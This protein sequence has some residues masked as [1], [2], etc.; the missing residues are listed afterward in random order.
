MRSLLFILMLAF[1]SACS[2]NKANVKLKVSQSF[3][4]SAFSGGAALLMKNVTAKT[5]KTIL[6]SES[7]IK[8][9]LVNGDWEFALVSWDGSTPLSGT[10]TC[11]IEKATLSGEPV[12]ID[13]IHSS[14]KCSDPYFTSTPISLVSCTSVSGLAVGDNCDG[15]KRGYAESYRVNLKG[16]DNTSLNS[17]CIQATSSP[18]SLTDSGITLPLGSADL[19][20]LMSVDLFSDENCLSDKRSVTLANTFKFGGVL[21]FD[22]YKSYPPV[23]TAFAA[24]NLTAGTES[25]I[26]L[27]YSDANLEEASSCTISSLNNLLITT[28]CTCVSGECTVGVSGAVGYAGTASFN[29]SVVVN[30]EASNS[31]TVTLNIIAPAPTITYAAVDFAAIAGQAVSIAPTTIIDHGSPIVSCSVT[32]SLPA[33]LSINSTTCEISG[34]PSGILSPTNYAISAS[35][36][37]GTTTTGITLT[38]NPPAPTLSYSGTIITGEQGIG[39][40][41]TPLSFS[42]N[43]YPL[44]SCTVTPALPDGMMINNNDCMITGTPTLGLPATTFTVSASNGSTTFAPFTLKIDAPFITTWKTDNTGISTTT[45][46]KIPLEANATYNFTVDWGDG[47]SNVIT[48]W[49]DSALTHTYASPGTYTVKITGTFDRIYFNNSGDKLKLL[50]VDQWGSMQWSS[51]ESAFFGCANLQFTALDVPDLSN[52]TNM[53]Y[54]LSGA[55][56]FNSDINHWDT[57]TVTNMSYLFQNTNNFNQPLGNWNT[58]NVTTMRQM[59]QNALMFNQPLTNWDT[60][61]VTDMTFM[62]NYAPVFNSDISGWNTGNVVNMSGLFLQASAFNQP[63]GAWD[64]SKVTTMSSMFQQTSFN[65]P[66]ES[67]NT[68]SVTNMSSMFKSNTMFNQPLGNWNI[69]NVTNMEAMFWGA[70]AFN[71]PIGTWDTSNVTTIGSTFKG[72]SSFNQ[73]LSSWNTSGITDMSYT[74]YNATSFD[75]DLSSWDTTAV[76]TSFEYD[77]GASAWMLPKPF[78]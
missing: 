6:L 38:I 52:V 76:A 65:Q 70:T 34:T 78:P 26:V 13:L 18:G 21:Y 66:I 40:T 42:D 45:Q 16:D 69:G 32:P 46:I 36:A 24:G 39:L 49:N 2:G 67:W 7:E 50:S 15:A 14:Q 63:I 12:E 27:T 11:A 71:Q 29:Y 3:A 1:F 62:F 35:N 20:S 23:T 61:K 10:L 28:A 22:F 72:A 51:M 77:V 41:I 56:A 30:G 5:S 55:T 4:L 60:S 73:N 74:F 19:T 44:V 25:T 9:N 43:G 53:S 47:N 17:T 75:Q 57:S 48:Y 37:G 33:G 68:S 64:T 58:S 31:S 59:F 8:V 54:M